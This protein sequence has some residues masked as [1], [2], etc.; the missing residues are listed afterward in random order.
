MQLVCLFFRKP[1]K[2]L[3]IA[4]LLFLPAGAFG[5]SFY[6][7]S[8]VGSDLPVRINGAVYVLDSSYTSVPTYYPLFDTLTFVHEGTDEAFSVLCNFHPDSSYTV[9]HACCGSLDLVTSRKACDKRLREWSENYD[10]ESD[11]IQ[12]VLMDRPSFILQ[13]ENGTKAD[14]IYGW[15]SDHACFPQFRLLDNTGWAYGEAIKCFYWS[16]ISYFEFFKSSADY[17]SFM[18]EAGIVEDVYPD[19]PDTVEH[20]GHVA[21]RLFDDAWYVVSYDVATGKIRLRR[22]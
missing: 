17:R 22:E 5:Q 7:Q 15:Y 6:L 16:N 13:L 9:I 3:R 1:C 19:F 21:V 20:L 8:A 2:F 18:N 4:G 11:K 12:Q 10:T 14:S